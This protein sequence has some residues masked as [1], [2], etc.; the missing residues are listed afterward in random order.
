M[1][2]RMMV[3]V[4]DHAPR[5]LPDVQHRTLVALAERM[6]DKTR[7]GFH[8]RAEL[9]H[10]IS[11]SE[12]STARILA[13][14]VERGLLTVVKKAGRGRATVYRMAPLAAEEAV[15]LSEDNPEKEDTQ[16]GTLSGEETPEKDDAQGDTLSPGED[17]ERVPSEPERET[18]EAERVPSE[19][20][21]GDTQ[22]DTPSLHPS[23]IPHHPRARGNRPAPP[24]AD[25]ATDDEELKT[26]EDDP[27]ATAAMVAL[28]AHTH[29]TITAAHARAV[30]RAIL[31]GRTVKDPPAYVRSAVD[32]DPDRHIPTA[33]TRTVAEALARPDETDAA[34][35]HTEDRPAEVVDQLAALRARWDRDSRDRQTE[36]RRQPTAF[37]HLINPKE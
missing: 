7:T 30:A 21:K 25:A 19:A 26:L 8:P 28:R 31:S 22:G 10:R 18:D 13:D 14:L 4:L 11:R 32:R 15:T 37:A 23:D 24:V 12:R 9:A 29:R 5:E 6:N 20:L 27:A 35:R 34:P 36:E 17:T 1:S 33:A 3:E 2:V 16:D